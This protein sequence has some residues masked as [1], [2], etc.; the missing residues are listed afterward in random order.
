MAGGETWCEVAAHMMAPP[1]TQRSR[2]GPRASPVYD[3]MALRGRDHST[4]VRRVHQCRGVADR[5]GQRRIGYPV[6]PNDRVRPNNSAGIVRRYGHETNWL[7]QTGRP[8]GWPTR[9]QAE[10]LSCYRPYRRRGRH[11]M[12]TGVP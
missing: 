5:A 9:Y 8:R 12:A 2:P 10:A 6:S 3:R 1:P 7:C 11:V 4:S